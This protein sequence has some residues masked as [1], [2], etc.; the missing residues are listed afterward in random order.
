MI[1][2]FLRSRPHD[3]FLR[4]GVGEDHGPQA[5]I[6]SAY[7]FQDHAQGGRFLPDAA[8]AFGQRYAEKS[9]LSNLG[10]HRIIE[11][12]ERIPV[13]CFPAMC[14]LLAGKSKGQILEGLQFVMP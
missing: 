7:A 2:K 9:E 10:Q 8:Q 4:Q 6:R 11:G 1:K 14:Q 13:A 3:Y 12:A 5:G